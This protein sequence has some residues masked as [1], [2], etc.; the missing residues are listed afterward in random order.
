MIKK[1]LFFLF[2]LLHSLSYSQATLENIDADNPLIHYTGRI[3]H[4]DPKAIRFAY[5]GVSIFFAFEG[6]TCNIRLQDKSE[7]TSPAG[8][9]NRNFYNII[10]DGKEPFVLKADP[11]KDMYRIDSLSHGFHTIKIFK[12]T[13]AQV[14]EGIFKGFQIEKGGLPKAMVSFR[15]KLK[16]EF[17]GNSITCGYGNEGSGKE[18]PFSPETEN[19]YLAY[20]ALTARALDAEYVAVAYSGKGVVQ[21]YDKTKEETMPELYLRTLPE[22]KNSK[23]DFKRYTPN[24]VVI[25]LGTNDFAH[26]NPD[27]ALWVSKYVGLVKTIRSH[28]PH[29]HII[30]AIG[31]MMSD[32]HPP[33]NK[34]LTT[35]TGYLQAVHHVLKKGG[36]HK[37]HLYEFPPQTG[38]YGC[39]WHPG[40]NTHQ[41]MSEEL[42]K[43]IKSEIL[44]KHKLED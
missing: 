13:E 18:C 19:N 43:F 20:G 28:Y 21:N 10:I 8:T 14:G 15:K 40:V 41:K 39:D 35:I 33:G 34:A 1:N 25:N 31:P 36:D 26:T 37:V 7:G 30:C 17:I 9:P 24:I 44:N 32:A 38:G 6:R 29:A 23:W 3:D 16:L 2:L 22:D 27:S 4:S 42:A 5:P 12:R 11:T